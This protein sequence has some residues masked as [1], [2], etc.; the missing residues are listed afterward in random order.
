MPEMVEP[1]D[2]LWDYV[3]MIYG[4]KNIGKTSLIAAH[5]QHL[6]FGWEPRRRNVKG[7]IRYTNA[8]GGPLDWE[9][10]QIIMDELLAKGPEKSGVKLVAEDTFARMYL[11]CQA[12]LCKELGCEHPKDMND[13]GKTWNKLKTRVEESV[14]QL[15]MAG[16]T[17]V[18]T[19]HAKTREE[20]D[21]DPYEIRP[22]MSNSPLLIVKAFVDYV[23]YFGMT[24]GIRTFT[25]RGG[26]EFFT[27]CASEEHFLCK[28]T[29]KPLACF[30]AGNTRE[31]GL[32]NLVAAFNNQ[33]TGI[34]YIPGAKL[35]ETDYF[36]EK[37]DEAIAA[38]L[39]KNEKTTAQK[40]AAFRS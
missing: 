28:D 21:P 35:S 27:A 30:E 6:I 10:H 33:R 7:R 12:H 4:L 14:N 36:R 24:S 3:L 9:T 2:S 13:Y 22:S 18:F 26:N 38:G 16:Y 17:P 32:E 20:D 25:V 39:I 1:P 34:L 5:P 15:C 31:E 11:Q 23:I 8:E 19:D 29:G 40:G 37:R